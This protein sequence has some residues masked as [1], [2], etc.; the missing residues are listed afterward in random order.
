M[1]DEPALLALY[2]LEAHVLPHFETISQAD[3]AVYHCLEE[4]RTLLHRAQEILQAAV[5]DP[6][7]HYEESR[8]FYRN[9]ARV[10]PLMVVLESFGP[11][12]PDPGEVG[13]SPD[14][15]SSDQSDEDNY[16]PATPPR[17]SES[18]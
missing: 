7:T 11:P 16:V 3:P 1:N 4:A 8:R 17:H 5:L 15:P 10:L 14:T 12:P 2:D 18:E 9:L 6:Q 13:N